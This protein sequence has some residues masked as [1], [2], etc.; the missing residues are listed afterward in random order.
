LEDI[1]AAF[2]SRQKQ[3]QHTSGSL[4]SYSTRSSALAGSSHPQSDVT[5]S[6]LLNVLDGVASSEERL[7]FMTTNHIDRL[8]PALIRPG[9]VDVV[10]LIGNASAY[11]IR[12]MF[13]KFYMTAYASTVSSS[14]VSNGVETV[15]DSSLSSSSSQLMSEQLSCQ[16][17]AFIS[18]METS[19]KTVSMAQLQG[20]FMR[21][22]HAPEE[23][24]AQVADLLSSSSSPIIDNQ[25]NNKHTTTMP[26]QAQQSMMST[27]DSAND[28]EGRG[29]GWR[30]LSVAEVDRMVFNPQTDWDK[31]LKA[32]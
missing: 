9:R 15:T 30:Q 14:S 25:V 11:Q 32:L 26:L 4:S 5:F 8:D 28:S 7:L 29:R 19:G 10:H 20:H 3:Q 27:D 21:F 1:D 2:P 6:G 18:I 16:L 24:L 22:K 17:E 13:T 12:A 23:S 31:G